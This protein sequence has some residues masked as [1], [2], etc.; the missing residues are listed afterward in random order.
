M[1]F[2]VLIFVSALAPQVTD[3]IGPFF[4]EPVSIRRTQK[5][6]E[7][8]LVRKQETEEL[9]GMTT[10]HLTVLLGLNVAGDFFRFFRIRKSLVMV[11]RGK[12]SFFLV[13]QC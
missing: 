13:L 6:E 2:Y 8:L 7:L 1:V 11:I 12:N 4:V 3:Q 10:S 5:G 9:L